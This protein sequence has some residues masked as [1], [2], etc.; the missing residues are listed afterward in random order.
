MVV[1]FAA[2]ND[3][4]LGI[5]IALDTVLPCLVAATALLQRVSSL[6][7]L[8]SASSTGELFHLLLSVDLR[9]E[10]GAARSSDES[11]P[12]VC[13]PFARPTDLSRRGMG[14]ADAKTLAYISISLFEIFSSSVRL[15]L[16]VQSTA[17]L[18]ALLVQIVAWVCV[19]NAEP[20]SKLIIPYIRV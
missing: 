19:I 13:E 8:T 9:L 10:L 18:A 16:G 7:T 1:A 11:R 17:S 20:N 4:V 2:P 3:I 5:Q 6:P 15:F 14:L 12:D